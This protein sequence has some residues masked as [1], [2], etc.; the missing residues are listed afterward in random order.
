ML[1][2]DADVQAPYDVAKPMLAVNT[3][4]RHRIAEMIAAMLGELP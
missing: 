4:D 2:L 3:E 1:L